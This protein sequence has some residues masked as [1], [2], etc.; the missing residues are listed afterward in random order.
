MAL[1]HRSAGHSEVAAG[2]QAHVLGNAGCHLRQLHHREWDLLGHVG[3]PR[4]TEVGGDRQGEDGELG[5]LALINHEFCEKIWENNHF[6][7]KTHQIFRLWKSEKRGTH[8]DVWF[9]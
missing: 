9:T 4:W 3:R 1:C 5:Q 6:I 2:H 8:A 7:G